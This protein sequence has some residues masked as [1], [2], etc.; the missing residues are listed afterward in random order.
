M[1]QKTLYDLL[2]CFILQLGFYAFLNE[3]LLANTLSLA[4]SRLRERGLQLHSANA[5]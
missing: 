4:L 1:K 3:V 2:T 5:R